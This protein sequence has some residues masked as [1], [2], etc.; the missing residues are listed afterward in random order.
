MSGRI[1]IVDDDPEMCEAIATKLKRLGWETNFC[2]SAA[3]ARGFFGAHA[4][5][6][7]L[8]DLS[9]PGG[10]GIELCEWI[11]EN[12]PD[13]PVVVITAFGSLETAVA[14]IRAGAYDFVTK[15]IELDLLAV[16]LARA[17]EHRVLEQQVRRL[18]HSVEQAQPF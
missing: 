3:E 5:D 8:T 9:M 15:P 17:C 10:N 12:R 18:S 1:L 6:V 13:V 2:T 7:V 14:A 11:V 16:S 4:C